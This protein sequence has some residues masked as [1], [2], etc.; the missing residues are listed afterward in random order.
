MTELPAKQ[1]AMSADEPMLDFVEDDLKLALTFVRISSA[2]YSTGK[3]KH[4]GDARSKAEAV[5]ARAVARLIE[6]PAAN[7][8]DEYVQ[9]MLKEVQ[10]ALSSLPSSAQPAWWMR[11]AVG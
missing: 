10:S 5:H 11:R 6:S 4:G 3:L 1:P 8:Q 9:S 7:R 2:A